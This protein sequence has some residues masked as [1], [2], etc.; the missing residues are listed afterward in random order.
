MSMPEST[1]LITELEGIVTVVKL[2]AVCKVGS[3]RQT[4]AS[5][6]RSSCV[7]GYGIGVP[8][9]TCSLGA[10]L[11]SQHD[12]SGHSSRYE[13]PPSLKVP[14]LFPK[15]VAVEVSCCVQLTT[16]NRCT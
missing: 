16:A 1:L 11:I 3:A 5:A 9:R 15:H 14:I 10:S 6:E 13:L 12:T 4:K 2:M 8:E 7:L